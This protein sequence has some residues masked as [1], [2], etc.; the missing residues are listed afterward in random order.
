MGVTEISYCQQREVALFVMAEQ[1]ASFTPTLTLKLLQEMRLRPCPLL[2]WNLLELST[3]C[4]SD[5][6]GGSPRLWTE[7][8]HFLDHVQSLLH[9]A[10]DNMP[11]IQPKWRKERFI[12][13]APDSETIH[14]VP[15]RVP[16]ITFIW[17]CHYFYNNSD[18]LGQHS[19]LHIFL[20]P[21]QNIARIHS[22]H[23]VF[24]SRQD[25]KNLWNSI[26]IITGHYY[27]HI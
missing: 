22:F 14:D 5:P 25:G 27:A 8:L 15:N 24:C 21:C 13:I 3:V 9:T 4:D 18:I 11:A 17:W 6:L 23:Q 2:T 7:R 20:L 10:K 16:L 19:N 26:L 12:I 1:R